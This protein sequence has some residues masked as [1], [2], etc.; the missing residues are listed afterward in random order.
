MTSKNYAK[1]F[2][3]FFFQIF[4]QIFQNLSARQQIIVHVNKKPA[5]VMSRWSIKFGSNLKY[6]KFAI[7]KYLKTFP[8]GHFETRSKNY[9]CFCLFRF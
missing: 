3:L 6:L 8:T 2:H 1:I 4:G 7:F 9:F 5:Y